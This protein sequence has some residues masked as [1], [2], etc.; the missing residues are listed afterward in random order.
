MYQFDV[1]PRIVGPH[2]LPAVIKTSIIGSY[3]ERLVSLGRAKR[4]GYEPFGYYYSLLSNGPVLRRIVN[5]AVTSSSINKKNGSNARN[6]GGKSDSSGGSDDDSLGVVEGH[7]ASF[8]DSK[9][10][11]AFAVLNDH[12]MA[13]IASTVD[14]F[15]KEKLK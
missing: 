7:L 14:L 6:S 10:A 1:V 13:N 8:P 15:C 9:S 11:L 4:T 5:Q 12:A 2:D 3:V